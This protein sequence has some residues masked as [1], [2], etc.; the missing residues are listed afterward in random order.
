M[1]EIIPLEN[2]TRNGG[3]SLIAWGCAFLQRSLYRFVS[4]F[5]I[6]SADC[7]CIFVYWKHSHILRF[8]CHRLQ[9]KS[10]PA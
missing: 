3:E 4:F 1:E 2:K 6:K 5:C 10:V 8:V 9:P 7:E